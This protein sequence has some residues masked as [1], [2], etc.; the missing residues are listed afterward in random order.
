[1]VLFSA[2]DNGSAAAAADAN[3]YNNF[4]MQ[5]PSRNAIPL[6]NLLSYVKENLANPD[7]FATEFQVIWCS[8]WERF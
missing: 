2:D 6:S 8:L 4:P 7:H 5:G 1:M 3:I